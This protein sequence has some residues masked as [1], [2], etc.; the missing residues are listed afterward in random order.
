MPLP[1][2]LISILPT[3]LSLI[4][5]E[6]L[7]SVDNALAIAALA[8]HLPK[9]QQ[10]LALRLG[11]LG[12]YVFRGI[13]LLL[14]A[15]I[16]ANPWLKLLG[17]AYLLY[18]MASH[19][20]HHDEFDPAVAAKRRARKKP[21]L[22]GAIVQIEVMDLSLSLDNV[23]A[24]VALDQRLWVVCTGVFIGILAL[25]VAAGYCIQLI[26]KHPILGVTAFLL[27]GY[28]G[29]ILLVEIVSEMNGRPVHITSFQK[30]AGIAA[31][32][33]ISLL[34]EKKGIVWRIFRPLVRVGKPILV[35]IDVVVGAIFWP[36]AKAIEW[37]GKKF[38]RPAVASP[39]AE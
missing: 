31:I 34:Y 22:I 8:S 32:V 20:C 10:K 27:I 25:R 23:V 21:G 37:L 15:L 17:A 13:A 1:A 16:I 39:P 11:I 3:I 38:E 4:V 7:L 36:A 28:V 14:V 29:L 33:T 12:A 18:L 30:F 19:L 5:I 9:D 35:A 26:E 24:A 2:E 6:A